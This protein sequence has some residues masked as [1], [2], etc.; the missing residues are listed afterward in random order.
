MKVLVTGGYGFIGSHIVAG[1]LAAGHEPAGCGRKVALGRRLIPRIEWL[2]CDLNRDTD[3]A[4]WLERVKGF[5]AVVNCAGALQ[6]SARDDI[7]AIHRRGPMA[8]FE[9]CRIA[10]VRRVVQVSALGVEGDAGT[11]YADS[12]RAADEALMAMDL[13][14]VVLRPSL[15]YARNC[16]GGTALFRGLAALPFAIPLPG[17]GDQRFQPIHMDDLVDTVLR[18]LEANAPARQLLSPVGP[19][20][21]TLREILTGLRQW[22][23]LPPARVVGIPMPAIRLAAKMGDALHWLGMRGSMRSTA[24]KQME[25]DNVA[26][27]ASFADAVGFTPRRFADALAAEPAGTQDRWHARLYFLRPLLRFTLAAFWLASGLI[28]AF[29]PA[30]SDALALLADAGFGTQ[31]ALFALWGGIAADVAIGL[32]VLSDRYLHLAGMLMLGVTAAYLVAISLA[33][34]SLWLDPLGPAVKV[35]PLIPAALVMLAL[36]SDR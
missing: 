1:L 16:Y 2:G 9:A 11:A 17:A 5:D 21:M 34:P 24:L 15:V 14:W 32:L 30:R 23:G 36:E 18:C 26:D 19:Q 29:D 4:D 13:D 20:P 31:F 25:R 33:L 35:L 6:G 27:L 10:G 12:K 28:A 22:L 8:L 3:P 7:D